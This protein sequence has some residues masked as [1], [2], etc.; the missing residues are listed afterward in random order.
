[1][2]IEFNIYDSW[3]QRIQ[4]P[5]LDVI[6]INFDVVCGGMSLNRS[7][8]CAPVDG[9]ILAVAN[10]LPIQVKSHFT[11][12]GNEEDGPGL[13][14]P[15]QTCPAITDRVFCCSIVVADVPC[16]IQGKTK[17]IRD[18]IPLAEFELDNIRTNRYYR[19]K[20]ELDDKISGS[21][22]RPTGTG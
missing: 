10:G 1:M 16:A 22:M 12:L 15:G 18:T 6:K 14:I 20:I 5:E 3:L 2:K 17:I 13:T 7:R 4:I 21:D 19:R 11:A 8:I 9:I